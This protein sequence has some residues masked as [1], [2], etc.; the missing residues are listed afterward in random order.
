MNNSRAQ[1]KAERTECMRVANRIIAGRLPMI[2]GI[3]AI[4]T[5]DCIEFGQIAKDNG[6]SAIL[7]GA[8]YYAVPT[9]QEL[10]D[11]ALAV[12]REVDLP[13]MLYNYPG[14][15]GTSSGGP[16]EALPPQ[17]PRGESDLSRNM[18]SL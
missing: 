13:I 7:M 8:P 1:S 18:A 3:G 14:R 16:A 4:R 6:A 15:T 5:E 12:D 10:A 17:P 2:A 11:H 9:Q